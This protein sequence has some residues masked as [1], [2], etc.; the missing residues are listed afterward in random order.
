MNQSGIPFYVGCS[1]NTEQRLYWHTNQ[2]RQCLKLCLKLGW[3]FF[4]NRGKDGIIARMLAKGLEPTLE[5]IASN[6]DLPAAHALERATI[7]KIG[8]RVL[9]TGPLANIHG[10][11]EL[12]GKDAGII[13]QRAA[14]RSAR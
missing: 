2:G 12:G 3:G 9:G 10:G 1:S 14:A 13:A 8:R 11:G 4:G 5:I 7:A 6:L